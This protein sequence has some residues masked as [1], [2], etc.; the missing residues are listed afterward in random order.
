[1]FGETKYAGDVVVMRESAE[2]L[3]SVLHMVDEYSRDFGVSFTSEKCKIMIVNNAED[4]KCY[5]ET[6]SVHGYNYVC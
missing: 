3:L 1:M 4:E 5:M 6:C 2:E